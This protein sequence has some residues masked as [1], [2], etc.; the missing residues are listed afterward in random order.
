MRPRRVPPPELHRWDLPDDRYAPLR[1]VIVE[2]GAAL[3]PLAGALDPTGRPYRKGLALV[4]L[5]DRPM[6]T[7]ELALDEGGLGVEALIAQLASAVAEP[8]AAVA[9]SLGAAPP[10]PLDAGGYPTLAVPEPLHHAPAFTVVVATRERPEPLRRCLESLADLVYEGPFEV[11]VVDNV[12]TSDASETVVASFADRLH[13]R[14]VREDHPGLAC[15]HNAGI[16]VTTTPY[17]AITDDDVIVDRYWLRR[18]ALGF[19]R[20]DGVT[21]VTG[22]IRPAELDHPAQLLLEQ[23]G[24][25]DKGL[26]PRVYDLADHRPDDPLFPFA[27]G[28]LGSGANMAFATAPLLARGGFDPALGAGS[29]AKG[30]DDLAAFYEVV[31]AGDRLVYEPGAIIWHHHHRRYRQLRKVMFGYGAGFSAFLTKTVVDQPGTVWELAR[32]LPGGVRHALSP[33]SAKNAG[34]QRGFP[35]EL[36]AAELVGMAAG[37]VLY[38]RS[39]LATRHLVL[40]PKTMSGV[41]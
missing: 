21:C 12:P 34:K 33:T 17:V 37:P 22:M 38:L 20:A 30:A 15:A 4:R 16:A 25:Y 32:K 11:V 9:A 3:E 7:V 19:G 36:T 18:L 13:I 31:T 5:A 27:A 23:F 2:V 14:Y 1:S 26:V 41:V 24:G 8:V 6:V 39:R 35:L 40:G 28:K 29:R 10:A